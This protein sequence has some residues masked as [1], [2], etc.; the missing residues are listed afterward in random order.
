M[1]DKWYLTP[2]KYTFYKR[3]KVFSLALLL[4]L[5]NSVSLGT[6]MI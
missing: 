2:S 1:K 6:R 3:V 5:G 4:F